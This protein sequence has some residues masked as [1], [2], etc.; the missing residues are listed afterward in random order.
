MRCR[1]NAGVFIRLDRRRP[2]DDK[3]GPMTSNVPDY[4]KEILEV[5]DHED[6]VIGTER[7]GVVHARGLMHRSAQVLLFNS[8]GE[9]FLQKRSMNKDEFPGLWDSSAAGHLAPGESYHQCALREL[10][11]ELGIRHRG[12]LKELFRIP[13]SANTGYEHCTVFRCTSDSPVILQEQE[14]DEGKW[15]S[16]GEMDRWVANRQTLLTPAVRRIWLKFRH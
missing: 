4:S 13:A 2:G 11:E 15:L 3:L 1:V 10:E 8:S 9:L 14:V 6:R 16:P 7:R 5:V 12:G